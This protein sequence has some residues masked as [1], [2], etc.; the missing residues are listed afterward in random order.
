MLIVVLLKWQDLVGTVMGMNYCKI[1]L[2]INSEP[3]DSFLALS[4]D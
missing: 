2:T 4:L 1:E 3:K